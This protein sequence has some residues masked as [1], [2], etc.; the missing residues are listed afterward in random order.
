MQWG[1][2]DITKMRTGSDTV[3][4]SGIPELDL[5]SYKELIDPSNGVKVLVVFLRR[6]QFPGAWMEWRSE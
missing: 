6:A 3:A 2:T 1:S 4:P 5:A